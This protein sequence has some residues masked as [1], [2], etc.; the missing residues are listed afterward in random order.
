MGTKLFHGGKKNVL[1]D[2][3]KLYPLWIKVSATFL[4]YQLSV[5]YFCI[6][7]WFGYK[8]SVAGTKSK[9]GCCFCVIH[10]ETVSE[11]FPWMLSGPAA[12]HGPTLE[13]VLLTSTVVGQSTCSPDICVGF[14]AILLRASNCAQRSFNMSRRL[15]P[16]LLV[17]DVHKRLDT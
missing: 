5:F 1:F 11:H 9:N 14:V 4:Q 6:R 17:C 12:L 13:N 8:Q 16:L 3:T 2:S 15:V 10:D 7:L